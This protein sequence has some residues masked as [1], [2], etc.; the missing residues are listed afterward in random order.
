MPLI[1]NVDH[2]V[3]AVTSLAATASVAAYAFYRLHTMKRKLASTEDA[4]E[5]AKSLNERLIF[6]YGLPHEII[7]FSFGPKSDVDFPTR[8]AE[9][10]IKYSEVKVLT[11]FM[12]TLIIIVIIIIIVIMIMVSKMSELQICCNSNSGK[13]QLL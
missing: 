7:P 5:P 8:C 6:H 11:A 12:V 1:F 13:M 10:C 2:K 9:L 4:D 3:F